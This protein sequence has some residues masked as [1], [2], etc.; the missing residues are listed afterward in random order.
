[1]VHFGGFREFVFI[2]PCHWRY[3]AE[4]PP[5]GSTTPGLSHPCCTRGRPVHAL[6]A[7]TARPVR[8]RKCAGPSY[9]YILFPRYLYLTAYGCFGTGTGPRL[10][11]SRWPVLTLEERPWG[12]AATVGAV[13]ALH[14]L[15]A[16]V[17]RHH[18]PVVFEGHGVL[19]A[20]TMT[21]AKQPTGPR[22]IGP[23]PA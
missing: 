14:V 11:R 13:H 1:M 2:T 15:Q 3:F 10:L 7:P 17:A 23:Q 16:A 6:F 8:V 4:N 20:L 9:L 5:C 18:W 22:A 19:A 21:L 12:S